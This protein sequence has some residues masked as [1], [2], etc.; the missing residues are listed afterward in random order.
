MY[1]E[2][3]KKERKE[4]KRREK[5]GE[6]EITRERERE[7]GGRIGR[8]KKRKIKSNV[9]TTSTTPISF[10]VAITPQN[11]SLA[12]RLNPLRA[13]CVRKARKEAREKE[14]MNSRSVASR[15]PFNFSVDRKNRQNRVSLSLSLLPSLFP[16]E[17]CARPRAL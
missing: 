17:P 9:T 3:K 11:S 8:K 14:S 1:E 4:E 13:R 15:R 10:L 6:R 16:T 2:A 5:E 12:P 7:R